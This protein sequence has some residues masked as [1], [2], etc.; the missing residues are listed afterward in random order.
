[1]ADPRILT[2]SVTGGSTTREQNPSLP[3]TPEEIANSCLEAEEAGAAVCHIHVRDPETGGMSTELAH[4]R[5]VVERIRNSGSDLVINLTTG[6]GAFYDPSPSDPAVPGPNTMLFTARRRVEHVL[7][8]KPDICSL[9]IGSMN[10]DKNI[11]LNIPDL[12]REMCVL[13]RSAGTKPEIECFDTGD[14]VF[15]KD[16]IAEGLIDGPY[17]FQFVMGGK[18][19]AAANPELLYYLKNSLPAN[20]VW[21]AFGIGRHSFQTVASVFLAGGHSRIGLE[22]AIYM[23]RGVLANGNG[24]LIT[25]ARRII[26]D[27]GG[28]LATPAQAREILQIERR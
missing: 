26:E 14:V 3:V 22:D 27:L 25:K 4:Y 16:L 24:E 2:C 23:S 13:I 19:G 1:M 10:F 8:L 21:G 6:P 17:F 15:A 18:Y 7:D 12:V 20:S 11:V 5:E 9:D 28:E